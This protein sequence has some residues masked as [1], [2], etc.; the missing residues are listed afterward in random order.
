L[1]FFI[2]LAEQN[3]DPDYYDEDEE[4]DPEVYA[5][6]QQECCP[7]KGNEDQAIEEKEGAVLLMVFQFDKTDNRVDCCKR[8]KEEDELEHL[9]FVEKEYC[10]EYSNEEDQEEEDPVPLLWRTT[11]SRHTGRITL[12]I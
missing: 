4:A 11:K 10:P 1:R 2:H 7:E 12:W 3:G 6:V 8:G 9:P 5:E